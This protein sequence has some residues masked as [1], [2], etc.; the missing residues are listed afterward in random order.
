MAISFGFEGEMGIRWCVSRPIIGFISIT[1]TF[2]R[3]LAYLQIRTNKEL[4]VNMLGTDEEF[5]SRFGG[6]FS[7]EV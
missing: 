7:F 6:P 1:S 2:V 4:S 5:H 3:I